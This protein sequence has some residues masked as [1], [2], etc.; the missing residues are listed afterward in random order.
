M[1]RHH[2]LLALSLAG[3]ATIA[4]CGGDDADD[5]GGESAATTTEA[6]ESTGTSVATADDDCAF[7]PT[8]EVADA[9]GMELQLERADDTGCGWTVVEPDEGAIV[10]D[11]I[12]IQLDPEEYVDQAKEF[13]D[14]GTEVEVNTDDPAY[15]CVSIGAPIGLVIV[16]DI[17]S[18]ITTVFTDEERD[19]DI[20]AAFATL[21]PRLAEGS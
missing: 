19:A 10:L 2:A 20:A 11:R 8:S 5:G 12:P 18:N 4:A 17:G 3:L 7:I 15:A 9:V 16:D 13:C 6:S 21:L 14:D 1:R